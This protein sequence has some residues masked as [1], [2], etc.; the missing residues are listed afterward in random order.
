MFAMR[1]AVSQVTRS[2]AEAAFRR[3]VYEMT[4]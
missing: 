2:D 4:R 3:K 1:H